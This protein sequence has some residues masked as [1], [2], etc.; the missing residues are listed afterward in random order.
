MASMR[1]TSLRPRHLRTTRVTRRL[2]AASAATLLACALAPLGPAS[3]RA[4]EGGVSFWLSGSYA[5]FAAVPGQPGWS[6]PTTLY[7][8]NGSAS[9]SKTFSRGD[10]L[11]A[12]LDSQLPL[13]MFSPTWTPEEKFFG[14]QLS[15]S[16]T[17]GYGWN[18]TQANLSVSGVSST[19]NRSD[20]DAGG[21]DLY[22][23][24][25]IAWSSGV[26][27]W[28]VYV[29]GDLPVGSYSSTR[30][31]NIG[32]GHTAIDVGGGYTYFNAKS[33]LEASAVIGLTYNGMNTSTNYQNGV[34]S[35][36]DWDVSQALGANWQ[37][38]LA[39]YVYYQL[40]ADSG[41]GDH[42]GS[43]KSRVASIGPEVGYTFTVGGQQ[44]YANLRGYKEFWAQNRLEGYAVFATLSIPLGPAKK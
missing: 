27:N 40:T 36:V 6:L 16:L 5:S 17:F 10:A 11:N 31:S 15:L 42:V 12:G 20:T 4:D 2:N 26:N 7:Y 13:V 21:T 9:A 3:A 35:H 43:F 34:D 25:S 24:A 38:G 39:G 23:L 22:P 28:M 30:L 33:G 19:L 18:S 44:W 37:V 32:I 14:G 8:Y 29:T 41:S 1:R